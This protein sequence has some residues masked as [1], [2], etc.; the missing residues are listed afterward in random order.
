MKN[1][2]VEI[3]LLKFPKT[4]KCNCCN[5]VRDIYYKV[6]IK[7]IENTDLIAGDLDFCKL[8]GDNFSKV[9]GEE[10][11]PDQKVIKEFNF[12]M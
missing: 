2:F 10:L 6:L 5:R 1:E 4:Q 7:D 12:S 3:S 9:L 8:C 11:N